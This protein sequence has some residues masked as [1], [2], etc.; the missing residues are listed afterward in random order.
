MDKVFCA[1]CESEAVAWAGRTPLCYACKTAYEWGQ[2]SPDA[3]MSDSPPSDKKFTVLDVYQDDD[4]YTCFGIEVPD[5]SPGIFMTL[6]SE[7]WCAFVDD[8]DEAMPFHETGSARYPSEDAIAGIVEE[9][10]ALMM[11]RNP[12]L[13]PSEQAYSQSCTNNSVYHD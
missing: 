12:P 13:S 2:A 8:T 1:N 11:K 9:Y 4:G 10:I 3:V 5:C 6:H 7:G